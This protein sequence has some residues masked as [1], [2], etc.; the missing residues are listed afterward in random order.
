MQCLEITI[1]LSLCCS[2]GI[3]AQIKTEFVTKANHEKSLFKGSELLGVRCAPSLQHRH[4][5]QCPSG[6]KLLTDQSSSAHV[7]YAIM[8]CAC[9]E[10]GLE[11]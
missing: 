7:A 11:V 5:D 4:S 3:E 6:E 8:S 9:K 1:L 10:K 2:W